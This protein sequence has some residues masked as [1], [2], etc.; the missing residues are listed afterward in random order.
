MVGGLTSVFKALLPVGAT[1]AMNKIV[2]QLDLNHLGLC[3]MFISSDLL[4]K[5]SWNERIRQQLTSAR[6]QHGW[7]PDLDIEKVILEVIKDHPFPGKNY[8]RTIK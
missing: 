6:S 8:L 3:L 4:N 1:V 2:I 7:R 5:K